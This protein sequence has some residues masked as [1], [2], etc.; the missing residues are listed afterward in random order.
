MDPN[1]R[2]IRAAAEYALAAQAVRLAGGGVAA[3]VDPLDAVSTDAPD[4]P[5]FVPVLTPENLST[6]VS[7]LGRIGMIPDVIR[8]LVEGGLDAAR[9]IKTLAL[10]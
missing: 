6:I 8:G 5:V 2:L 4:L 9:I 3:P 7:D 1:E 10:A